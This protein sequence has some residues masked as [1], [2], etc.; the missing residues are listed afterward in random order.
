VTSVPRA[1]F[2]DVTANVRKHVGIPVIASNR[3]NMPD[4]AEEILASG[5]ADMVQMARPFWQIQIGLIKRQPIV[6]MRSTLVS[7]VIKPAWITHFPI[8][9]P[10]A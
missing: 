1:A 10:H 5:K 6:L 3:I 4:V 7:L 8:N 2:V 9:A